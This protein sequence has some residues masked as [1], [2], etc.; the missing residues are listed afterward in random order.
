M[1]RLK[2]LGIFAE[3]VR[4][5]SFRGAA[6]ALGLTPSA[7]S[8]HVKQLEDD[9]GAPLLYRST[10]RLSLTD[11]GERLFEAAQT[12]VG[13]AEAGLQQARN[14]DASLR[15]QLRITL[16]SALARSPISAA[17][18]RF[19]VENPKVA[20]DLHYSD[21]WEDLIAGRFDL[22]LRSGRM[23]DSSLICRKLWD[24]PRA[25]VA[26]PAFLARYPDW[27]GPEDLADVPWIR[28]AKMEG[29]RQLIG[30]KGQEAW[31]QQSGDI[32]VNNIEA[33]VDFARHG[34]ALASP[35]RH[36]VSDELATGQLVEVLQDWGIA[37]MPV[38][39]LRPAGAVDNPL[40]LR[41]MQYLAEMQG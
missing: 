39:T 6:R 30:P 33:M 20:L 38:Y 23:E 2:S 40:T 11:A 19:H 22:A 17:I 27:H 35:P 24:M 34:M 21:T 26:A 7:I 15:G 31:V 5:G 1:D 18:A 41:L 10:R 4:Q 36:C 14:P 8:Y 9:L 29:Q 16:T 28:F 13:V 12:M 3:T 25:L 32:T 37:P